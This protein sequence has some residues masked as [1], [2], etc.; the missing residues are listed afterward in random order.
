[1][2]CAQQ[3][4]LSQGI[5]G[6][7]PVKEIPPEYPNHLVYQARVLKD[8]ILFQPRFLQMVL[9]LIYLMHSLL[10][11]SINASIQN[12]LCTVGLPCIKKSASFKFTD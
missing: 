3:K 4:T 5:V 7:I 8:W 9:A 10:F 1:M 6:L 2:H 12:D 11:T